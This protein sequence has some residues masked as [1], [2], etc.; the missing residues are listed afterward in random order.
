M[1]FLKAF[2]MWYSRDRFSIPAAV[3]VED[4]EDCDDAIP[5]PAPV[6]LLTLSL[7]HI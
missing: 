6:T 4:D 1:R 5:S 2:F 7:I 3:V